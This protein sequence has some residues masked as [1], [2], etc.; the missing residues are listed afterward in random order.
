M[1]DWNYFYTND[2]ELT[3]EQSCVKYP[4]ANQLQQYWDDNKYSY[5]TFISDVCKPPS[6]PGRLYAGLPHSVCYC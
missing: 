2:L 3:I 5:F 6:V 1:Q 4:M